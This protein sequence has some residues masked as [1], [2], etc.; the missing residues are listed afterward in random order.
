MSDQHFN[1][2]GGGGGAGRLPGVGGESTSNLPLDIDS[3]NGFNGD[4]A[5]VGGVGGIGFS[6]A[7]DGGA[8]GNWGQAGTAASGGAAGL[9]GS[10]ILDNGA[11]VTLYG[12]TAARYINGNGSHP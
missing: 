5:G 3:Q 9:A 10:G 8:G 12:A 2:G 7:T 11:T 4:I 6:G 1:G